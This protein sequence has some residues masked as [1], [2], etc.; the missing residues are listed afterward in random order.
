MSLFLF[1]SVSCCRADGEVNR[2]NGDGIVL[3]SGGAPHGDSFGIGIAYVKES[4]VDLSFGL[5][6]GIDEV[7][8]SKFSQQYSTSMAIGNSFHAKG[9][10]FGA[11]CGPVLMLYRNNEIMQDILL[12]GD[13]NL[14]QTN[15][16]LLV[17]P[18]IE[19]KLKQ[20]SSVGI[21][22]YTVVSNDVRQV[23]L[24]GIIRF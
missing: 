24:M 3:S 11:F 23:F 7:H 19:V 8:T 6:Y 13:A 12:S 14:W 9:W 4:K 20:P 2:K 21:A 22:I 17:Q 5:H 16:G 18:Y 1:A 10:R 15:V